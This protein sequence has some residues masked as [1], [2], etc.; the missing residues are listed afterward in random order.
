MI[1]FVRWILGL[2]P[3]QQQ[4]RRP[5]EE[6]LTDWRNE[7]AQA[8]GIGCRLLVN[9][10]ALWSV[11]RC[12]SL[13]AARE[14]GSREGATL[15]LRLMAASILSAT[16]FIGFHW[17]DSITFEGTPT[18]VGPV[19]GAWLSIA[20]VLSVMPL[21][22]FA[23][24]TIGRRTT[25]SAPQFGPALM[26]GLVTFVAFGWLMPITNQAYRELT[27]AL[28]SSAGAV[29]P[30][31]SLQRGI[32]EHSIVELVGMA[33][34]GDV[35]QAAFGIN[36][37]LVFSIAVPVMLVVGATV[38]SLSGW[39]RVAGTLLLPVLLVALPALVGLNGLS[40]LA[41][42]PALFAIVLTTRV[43]SRTTSPQ[44]VMS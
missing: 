17:N 11:I 12:V 29:A 23:C 35:R 20:M 30:G 10:R 24:A 33:F 15:L 37:R 44:Q 19:A 13:I 34:T 38:R 21:L 4:G 9:A 5:C 32:N 39:R 31:F 28:A 22:A 8:R 40:E 43:L 6:T 3:V 42:W 25:R 14:V 16:L 36:V 7:A 1:P 41:W 26:A 2:L 27:F 18:S